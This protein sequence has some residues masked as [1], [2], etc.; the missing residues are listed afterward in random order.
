MRSIKLKIKK[1]I[2]DKK[3]IIEKQFNSVQIA[4]SFNNDVINFEDEDLSFANELN[5][6]DSIGSNVRMIKLMAQKLLNSSFNSSF[7]YS[8]NKY[9][10]Q[11]K[12]QIF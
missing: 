9:F 10:E 12:K 7:N 6:L 8:S 11:K 3:K 4:K 2:I 5:K 1:N